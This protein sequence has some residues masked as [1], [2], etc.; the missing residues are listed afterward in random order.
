[1]NQRNQVAVTWLIACVLSLPV[2]AWFGWELRSRTSATLAEAGISLLQ[3]DAVKL[4]AEI[5]KWEVSDAAL[6]AQL[7][8]S[9][10]SELSHQRMA[11]RALKDRNAWR[12]RALELEAREP[13]VVE[14][15][16]EADELI[17]K[18]V[19]KNCLVEVTPYRNMVIQLR[20]D[21]LFEQERVKVRDG[22]LAALQVAFSA[23]EM[24]L[25]DVRNQRDIQTERLA[26]ATQVIHKAKRNAKRIR[27]AGVA[28]VGVGVFLAV[29]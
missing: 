2:G 16:K 10:E 26:D 3:G 7:K 18:V 21:V 9:Q 1:M 17:A 29:R 5:R 27:I 23:R 13:E 11:E 6:N 24:E 19:P 12:S 14:H 28:L 25:A 15:I 20:E 8:K 4:Q 22:E